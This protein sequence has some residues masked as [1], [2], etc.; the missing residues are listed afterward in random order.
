MGYLHGRWQGVSDDSAGV[1]RGFPG[2]EAA[3]DRTVGRAGRVWRRQKVEDGH[4]H[5]KAELEPAP[6]PLPAGNLDF[7]WV[8]HIVQLVPGVHGAIAGVFS[9][10]LQPGTSSTARC[11]VNMRLKR[12]RESRA[13]EVVASTLP[14]ST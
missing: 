8:R 5:G 3:A 11:P 14:P 6:E 2:P 1:L 12:R 13:G 4:V 10:T 9:G 7:S